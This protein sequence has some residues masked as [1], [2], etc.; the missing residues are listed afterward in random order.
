MIAELIT[1]DQL[2]MH[3]IGDYVLQS[4]WMANE[5]TKHWYPALCHAITYSVGFVLFRPSVTAWLVIFGTHYLID[6]YRLARYVCWA[7]NFLAPKTWWKLSKSMGMW[8]SCSN[9]DAAAFRSWINHA[10]SLECPPHLKDIL[11]VKHA[12][13]LS[14]DDC[15]ATGYSSERPAW[16]TVWLL[17]ICDNLA[18]VLINALAL[19]LL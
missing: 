5:K 16:L 12:R 19:K 14:F 6:R 4:D 17:I 7:K 11:C 3:A 13:Y 15:I 2:A 1:A 18:H 10:E 8:S 9:Q